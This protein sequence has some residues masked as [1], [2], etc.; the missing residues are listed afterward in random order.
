MKAKV[1]IIV[2]TYQRDESLKR[3]LL[4]LIHQ[5]YSNMEIIVIDDNEPTSL[6]VSA[7]KEI[8]RELKGL[9]GRDEE[10]VYIKNK[11][12]IGSALSRNKGISIATGQYITFLDDDDLYEKEKISK[13]VSYMFDNN[14]EMCFTNLIL[15]DVNE[16]I[17][18]I[19]TRENITDYSVNALLTYHLKYHITGTNSFMYEKE[20]LVKLN[21]FDPIDI[22]DEFYLMY[23]TIKSNAKIGYLNANDV[24]AYVHG[25]DGGLSTGNGKIDGEYKLYSFKEKYFNKLSN[26][27]KRYIKFRHH[28]VL[29]YAYYKKDENIPAIKNGMI[30]LLGFPEIFL[31]EYLSLI[32]K[33]SKIYKVQSL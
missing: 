20:L 5:T 3:A 28:A 23:K 11:T 14:L 33:K 32:R 25:K 12:N 15:K 22:G 17:V 21:G 30:A 29:S 26:S 16:K 1:S 27:G 13:Q 4:S 19:R 8:V 9:C 7:V 24:V 10:I 18:D 2:P 31:K 6:Y